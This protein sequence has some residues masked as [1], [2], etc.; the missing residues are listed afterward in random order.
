MPLFI[1]IKQDEGS[2]LSQ[3]LVLTRADWRLS[4]P[5]IFLWI[6]YICICQ[7]CAPM[8][9]H[10]AQANQ[11]VHIEP[12]HSC[13]NTVKALNIKDV[14]MFYAGQIGTMLFR[15]AVTAIDHS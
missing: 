15:N 10:F 9:T 8:H 14:V 7:R 5:R 6:M 1:K 13:F 2:G 3:P 4:P 12:L 11:S